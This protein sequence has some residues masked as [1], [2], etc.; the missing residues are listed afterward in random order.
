VSEPPAVSVCIPTRNQED[1]IADTLQSAY[2]QTHLVHEV[3]VTDDAST[4]GTRETVESFRQSLPE[5]RRASLVYEHQAEPLGIGGNFNRA[6]SLGSGEF[7]VKVDSDDI[8][9]PRFVESLVGAMRDHPQAGW[10]HCN[11]LNVNPQRRPLE[12][13]HARKRAGYYSP[14]EVFNEYLEHNDTCHCVIIRKGA[15]DASGGYRPEMKTCEDWLL[16]LE[17][18][19]AGYGCVYVDESLAEMRKYRSR[20]EVMSRRRLQ[21]VDSARIMLDVLQRSLA[22]G[23]AERMGVDSN[24]A[25]D[26]LRAS[27][28]RH[29]KSAAIYETDRETQL[30]LFKALLTFDD[31]PGNRRCA[32]A[33]THFPSALVRAP[34]EIKGTARRLAKS[35][36]HRRS[37]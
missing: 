28:A 35:V 12:L 16:W 34:R 29:V 6:V 4:D 30:D 27:V 20:P 36:L 14:Q 37:S 22:N 8:L 32:W 10:A 31:S 7:C 25:Y 26:T 21:F 15:Y 18:C 5:S 13:A 3:I 17:M 2:E 11:I 19:L 23:G 33:G 1:L 24:R 9:G